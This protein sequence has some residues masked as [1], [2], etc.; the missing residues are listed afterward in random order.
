[1]Y[2]QEAYEGQPGLTDWQ[3]EPTVSDLKK[4]YDDATLDHEVHLTKLRTWRDN[5]TI[6]GSAVVKTK[7]GSSKHVPRTIRKHAEWRYPG[8]SEPFLASEDIFQ[9]L[10][11]TAKDTER[12]RQNGL[13]LNYQFNTKIDKVKF[14]D[15]YVRAV[16]DEG[17]A[18]IRVGWKTKEEEVTTNVPQ[19]TLVPDPD[20]KAEQR[21][22]FL[23]NLL[24]EDPEKAK[25]FINP[26]IEMALEEYTNSGGVFISI[27]K[28]SG[29][30]E[31]VELKETVNRPTVEVSDIENLVLDPT[32]GG[33]ME[34]AAFVVYSFETSL[35]ELK[36][37]KGKYKNLDKVRTEGAN[38]RNNPEYEGTVD[39]HSFEFSDEARK[40]I[41]VR[42]YWGEWDIDK[43]G[44]TKSI[45]AAWVGDVMIRMELNPMPD[46]QIPFVIIPYMPVRKSAYGE[47]DGELLEDNQKIIGALTRGMIDLMAKSANGQT[48]MRKDMLD[49]TNRRKFN[50]G[51][52]YEFNQITDPRQGIYMHTFPEIP[53]SAF[54]M[55]GMQAS[56]A[57]SLTGVKA[58]NNGLGGDT[59]GKLAAGVRG[60]LDA[61]SLRDSSILRRLTSGLQKVAYKIVAMNAVFLEED[62]IIRITDDEFVT[63][64]VDDL[65]GAY[66]IKIA[67]STAEEDNKRAEELSFMLQT[68]GN[69]VGQ[70]LSLMLL[71]DQARLRRMPRLA[72]KLDN[73]QPTPNPMEEQKLKLEMEEL[74]SQIQLNYAKAQES[75]MDAE[76]NR[77]KTVTEQT[78][79]ILNQAKAQLLG[80]QKDMVNL[81]FLEQESGTK[82]ERDLQKIGGQ[83]QAQTQMKVIE[84][85]ME[86]ALPPKTGTK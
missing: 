58:F 36:K 45:V 38:A 6:T 15:D 72:E 84:K 4:N 33:D 50:S 71:A 7:K 32:A 69:T 11:R 62:E 48:G 86:V 3:N 49:I 18:V 10:P 46:G 64:R 79:A 35:S 75:G 44:V 70:E 80:S 55:V 29:Y 31:N 21:Y 63:I 8:L 61:T 2:K 51:E 17:T 56:E 73:Y 13:V 67:V 1:M 14:I 9:V 41:V 22:T 37:E 47:P 19:Y 28:I 74:M 34:K 42:E 65:S 40:K 16:V 24:Q 81:D 25:Q 43:T 76:F 57:E 39:T 53:A 12:A 20:R 77:A 30:E 54:N 85:A 52:N 27:P 60:T 66:D 82:Q 68:I 83:A 23:L 59:Y 78:I 26:G 5:L